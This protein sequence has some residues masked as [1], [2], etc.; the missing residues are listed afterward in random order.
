[1]KNVSFRYDEGSFYLKNI[2]FE[3]LKGQ[4]VALVGASGSGKST[5]ADLI[6][7]FYDI[8]EGNILIDNKDIKEYTVESLRRMMGIVT[9]E[10][11]LLN[12]TISNNISYG[13]KMI[14]KD[15]VVEAAKAANALEFI[16]ELDNGFETII[17]ERGVKL[18]GGQKQRIAIARAIY[19][20]SII[21]H[22]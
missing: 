6:P 4:T 10:T 2:N 16:Q 14:K 21:T 19:K 15:D 12:T 17:G 18:S 20:K 13:S 5:I 3:I 9:Q 22:T 11:I 1:M 7:R 8:S